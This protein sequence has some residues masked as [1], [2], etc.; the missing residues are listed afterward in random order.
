MDAADAAAGGDLAQ[1]R[2]CAA[3]RGDQ[4]A[5]GV[6]AGADEAHHAR[7][8]PRARRRWKGDR[9]LPQR[10]VGRRVRVF[11]QDPQ[12]ARR[13]RHQPIGLGRRLDG[14]AVRDQGLHV[15]APARHQVKHR[16]E[17]A[18][19]GPADQ[20]ERIVAAPGLVLGVVPA[21]AVG[22]RHLERQLLL[23]EVRP[24]ELQPRD[25]DQHDAAALAAHQGGLVDRIAALGAGG[26]QHRVQAAP[27]RDALG[28]R[29]RILA[30]AEVRRLRAEPAGQGQAL[31]VHV[32]AQDPA[33]VASQDLHRHQPDQA[34]ARHRHR[35]AERRLDQPD[36]LQGDRAQHGEG[37]LVV[38]DRI[39]HAGAQV[40]RR[41]D[42]L[43]VPAV[44]GDAVARHE[45][46]DALA[47]RHHPADIAVAERQRLIELVAHRLQR[48]DQ[49]VGRQ[50][51][52]HLAHLFGLL[53]RLV[54]Q[55][56]LAE[57]HQHALG[58]R[59]H[60][61]AARTDQQLP[62]PGLRTGNLGHLGRAV[63]KVLQDLFQDAIRPFGDSP[64]CSRSAIFATMWMSCAIRSRQNTR[65]G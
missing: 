37:G 23:V 20:A 40:D 44:G 9:G 38:A 3:E 56:R 45:A 36:P 43:G 60:Q 10:L 46:G 31:G 33:A 59:R 48:R 34:Q 50:L 16:L 4:D 11:Q 47:R 53:A 52:Q 28:R 41:R 62:R 12:R 22:A 17:V 57:V 63:A 58:A 29:D 1:P 8:G 19:L 30:R 21:R 64:A 32:Q 65:P 2:P 7:A 27:A 51:V 61:R 6:P 42:D 39:G 18:L 49:P 14:E 5:A 13:A 35:L 24:R 26:D 55:V 25:P 54:D 15:Q